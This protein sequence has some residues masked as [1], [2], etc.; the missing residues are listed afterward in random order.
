MEPIE[1]KT[2]NY[3]RMT[4]LFHSRLQWRTMSRYIEKHFLIVQHRSSYASKERSN[5][6]N[7][8]EKKNLDRVMSHRSPIQFLLVIFDGGDSVEMELISSLNELDDSKTVDVHVGSG[9]DCVDDISEVKLMLIV[10]FVVVV[11]MTEYNFVAD[12]GKGAEIV[13][14]ND[15]ARNSHLLMLH[16]PYSSFM[17]TWKSSRTIDSGPVFFTDTNFCVQINL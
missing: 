17:F 13:D 5:K 1:K 10:V 16:S 3:Q 11:V 7:F 6:A 9:E 14:V 15:R 4:Y 12:D 8:L 2:T